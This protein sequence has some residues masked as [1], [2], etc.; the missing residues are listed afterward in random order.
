[1]FTIVFIKKQEILF[2]QC[3]NAYEKDD[4]QLSCLGLFSIADGIL[5]EL[6]NQIG[7]TGWH[8][9]LEAIQEKM[10]ANKSL[11]QFER[12]NY[13]IILYLQNYDNSVFCSCSF[14]CKEPDMLNRHWL[15]H[16]KTDR[17][18]SKIDFLKVLLLIDAMIILY[19]S[20]KQKDNEGD[21]FDEQL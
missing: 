5:G 14:D 18:Y 4:Y 1:M 17:D 15:V 11:N 20:E 12:V 6:S 9:R 10:L 13:L 21:G 16:G 3:L 8:K 19:N 7:S 2:R